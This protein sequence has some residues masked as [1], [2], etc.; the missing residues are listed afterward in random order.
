MGAP[1]GVDEPGR[2]LF[3]AVVGWMVFM[4]FLPGIAA[5]EEDGADDEGEGDV[6]EEDAV[7]P[8][9][10]PDAEDA[11]QELHVRIVTHL[12]SFEAR[13]RLTTWVYTVATRS[14]L[15]TRKRFV[16]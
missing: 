4:V 8:R 6:T 12:G 5:D 14:L 11:C 16:E 1:G 7:V 10:S 13:W 9:S 2:R 3:G 15:R